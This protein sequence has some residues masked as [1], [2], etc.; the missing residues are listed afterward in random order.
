[1]G[2]PTSEWRIVGR[3]GWFGEARDEKIAEYNNKYG[4]GNWRLRHK[5]G[6]RVL[7]FDQAVKLYELSYEL[8]FHH[9]DR[10]YLWND[11]I[12]MAS[13]VWTEQE[14]DVES[15][16][17]YAVQLAP[18]AHYEDVAIRRI[19]ETNR[20]KFKGDRLVRIRADSED[21]VG[22]VLSSIHIPFVYPNYI[23][24]SLDDKMP[25]WDRH[26]GSLECFWHLNKV[27]QVRD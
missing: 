24:G 10:R 22:K 3:P 26:K 7:D 2:I 25:W 19:L 4:E 17:D 6:P 27:L 1:M 8:D 18:A 12:N 9:P 11:L 20:L 23:E 14:S 15:G 13:D 5:L 21:T 16:I